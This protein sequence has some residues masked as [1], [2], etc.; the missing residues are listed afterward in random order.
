METINLGNGTKTTTV[1]IDR[2]IVATENGE[3]KYIGKTD[4]EKDLSEGIIKSCI[5]MYLD[6]KV[7]FDDFKDSGIHAFTSLPINAPFSD[8]I[9]EIIESVIGTTEKCILQKAYGRNGFFG[10]VAYRIFRQ[11]VGWS[12]WKKSTF[13]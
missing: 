11:S 6:S 5:K 1:G 13:I 2:V 7:D 3:H 10:Q 8:G 12:V 9:L 4:L